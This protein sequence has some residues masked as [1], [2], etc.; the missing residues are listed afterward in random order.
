MELYKIIVVIILQNI[1][2]K[3]KQLVLDMLKA[4]LL[5]NFGYIT[6]LA[7]VV[8]PKKYHSIQK[9]FYRQ[10]FNII[11]IQTKIIVAI[12]KYYNI[13]FI[14]IA[15]DDT[16]VYR[17]RKEKVPNGGEQY[18]HSNKANRKAH[19]YGQKWLAIIIVLNINGFQIS[20]PLWIHL[21]KP[22][23]NMITTTTV[24][25]QEIRKIMNK[26]SLKDL[27]VE[28]VMDSWFAKK[29]L[30]TRVL[31]R[32]KFSVI[33]MARVDTIC[34]EAL[35]PLAVGEKR[36][37]GRP[38]TKGEKIV[39]EMKD[40]TNKITLQLY[41]KMQEIQYVSKICKADFLGGMEIL[42][43]WVSFDGKGMRFILST[44]TTLSVAEV[45]KRY[46]QRWSIENMFNELKNNFRFKD[47]MVHQVATYYQ[48]FYF[49]IWCYTIIK[50]TSTSNINKIKEY[51][52]EMLPWRVQNDKSIKITAGITKL[53]MK[54]FFS[55]LEISVILPKMPLNKVKRFNKN[56]KPLNRAIKGDRKLVMSG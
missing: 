6:E 8:N 23:R 37:P 40:L 16:L 44:D 29:R 12:I 9:V 55:S 27:K 33:S 30:I 25:L 2:Y 35:K 17:S 7:T 19:V 42:A 24:I 39:V 54:S 1:Q 4:E 28:I 38:K 26:E 53:A 56:R 47:I 46:E 31:E 36:K 22:K 49:K 20:V 50:L 41:S 14:R 45:L 15:I 43:I 21:V 5:N 34:R 18:D 52:I 51:V 11:I 3:N 13:D 48:F 32:C 10:I